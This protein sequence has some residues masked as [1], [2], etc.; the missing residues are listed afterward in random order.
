MF[1]RQDR[2]QL[3]DIVDRLRGLEHDAEL[4]RTV[5]IVKEPTSVAAAESYEGLRK[6]IVAGAAER[7]S[8]LNQLVAMSVAVGR[9]RSLDDLGVMVSEWMQQAGV[10]EVSDVPTGARAQDLF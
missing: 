7:R 3:D 2:E 4:M 8:H 6:Q 1:R 10:I 9:A 5:L